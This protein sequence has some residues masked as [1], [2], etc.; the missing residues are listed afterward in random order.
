MK[1]TQLTTAALQSAPLKNS[2]YAIQIGLSGAVDQANDAAQWLAMQRR[3]D[4]DAIDEFKREKGSFLD[5]L[6]VQT[7]T[8]YRAPPTVHSRCRIHREVPDINRKIGYLCVATDDLENIGPLF[9][10]IE[11]G[12]VLIGR[13]ARI[14][15]ILEI[16]NFAVQPLYYWSDSVAVRVDSA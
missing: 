2:E 9:S 4:L 3:T 11:D 10:R 15:R 6:E 12:T 1:R 13:I 5:G 7:K 8:H 14:K 16:G